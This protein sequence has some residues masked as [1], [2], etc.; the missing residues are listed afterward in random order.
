MSLWLGQTQ[1]RGNGMEDTTHPGLPSSRPPKLLSQNPTLTLASHPSRR[2]G[3]CNPYRHRLDL[4]D[5][6]LEGCE[7]EL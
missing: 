5:S 2:A 7:Q 4:G 6:V 3:V 1:P